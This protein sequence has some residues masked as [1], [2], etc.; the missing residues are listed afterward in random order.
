[1]GKVGIGVEL[2]TFHLGAHLIVLLWA[3]SL[4]GDSHLSPELPE[5]HPCINWQTKLK[6][7]SLRGWK[8]GVVCMAAPNL[9][10]HT[11]EHVP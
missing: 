5:L 3:G 2:T 7:M 1:M 11:Q 6:E 8:A 9:S 4:A 10:S